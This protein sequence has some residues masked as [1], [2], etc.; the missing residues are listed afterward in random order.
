MIRVVKYADK[1]QL[2]TNPAVEIYECS[3]RNAVTSPGEQYLVVES[4]GKTFIIK[5]NDPAWI[6][7]AKNISFN[8]KEA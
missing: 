1:E 4:V 6:D 2:Q 7:F 3:A 5:I 8:A